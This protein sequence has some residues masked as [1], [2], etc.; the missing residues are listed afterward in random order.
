LLQL[1]AGIV[2]AHVSN[3]P[4]ARD[5]L[6]A[7]IVTVHRTL[8]GVGTAVAEPVRA[9]PAVAVK[10]SVFADHIVCLD[11]GRSLSML[12]RHL[13]TDHDLS[14]EAYR[15]KWGLPASYP[16][17]APDYAA[18]RSSLAKSI[19]LGR[20]RE[21]PAPAPEPVAAKPAKSAKPAAPPAKRGRP[22]KTV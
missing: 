2:S 12:K 10:K 17:V 15:Q 8:A 16:M 19:G 13:R 5:D 11:C 22:K 6:P 3:N 7:L 4:V 20:K 14:P 21:E 9:E 1:T 18:T